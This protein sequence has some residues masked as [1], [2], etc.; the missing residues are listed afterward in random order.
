MSGAYSNRGKA[1]LQLP[2]RTFTPCNFLEGNGGQAHRQLLDG[3][4]LMVRGS[5]Q[6][7]R[8]PS[9]RSSWPG[10]QG[11]FAGLPDR[12]R[13]LYTH[14]V[15]QSEPGE[16]VTELCVDAVSR[17]GQ[18]N[19]AGHLRRHRCRDLV[20]SDLRL[21]LK[22]DLDWHSTLPLTG[23]RPLD[24]CLVCRPV[25]ST[26]ARLPP[27]AYPSSESRCHLQSK[28]PLV[29]ASPSPAI[30]GYALPPAKWYRSTAPWLPN[31]ATIGAS[32]GRCPDPGAQPSARC[33]C[34][35][36]A[37]AILCSSSSKALADL[38]AP[39]LSPGPLYMP[40][41][42]SLVGLARKGVIPQNKSIP[43][44]SFMTQ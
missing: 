15:L 16:S 24:S 18:N 17:V 29:R 32:V 36:P 23:S 38:R 43:K 42:A 12:H 14:D 7:A 11:L 3:D 2:V 9:H 31:D 6:Q 33:S 39:R 5:L 25:R 20:Q 34:V 35:H 8:R 37:A 28:P 19:P 4:R 21:G 10:G 26:D 1:G 41:S 30:R 13:A 44:C 40:R 22:P 27:N